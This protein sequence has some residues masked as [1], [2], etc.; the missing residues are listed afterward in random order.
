[1]YDGANT[2]ENYFSPVK[3][4]MRASGQRVAIPPVVIQGPG[5][6]NGALC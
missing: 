1:M 3:S 5:P 6:L 2:I 4:E